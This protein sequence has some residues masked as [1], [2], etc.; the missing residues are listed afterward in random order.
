MRRNPLLMA[1][2]G[3]A[4][5]VVL[6]WSLIPIAMIMMSSFKTDRDIF[7]V[8]PRLAF[9]PTWTNYVALWERWGDFFHGLLNSLIVTAGATIV[10]VLSSAV[11]GYAYSR[12]RHKV[13]AGSAFFLIFIRLIPPIVITLPLFPAVNWL[14]L[15]DTHFILIVLYATFFVSL[16]TLVMRTFIDQIPKEVDEAA[17]LDGASRLQVLYKLILPLSAQGMVAVAVF[18]IVYAWNEFLFAFI[19]TTT[20]A[21]TAPLVLSEMIG[22]VEGVEWGVLFAASTVQ[23][24]P[25][26]IFVVLA[27]K[28]LVAGLTAGS[29]K[30]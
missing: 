9:Q 22:A 25:V 17:H 30:G 14:G 29:T 3:I 5:L 19:F 23:L 2:K 12:F 6:A 21:K 18:V 16:G 11:A 4:I 1:L 10:A 20:R 7:A 26:L 15:N 8:P 28:H 27:Q 24:L 13:L